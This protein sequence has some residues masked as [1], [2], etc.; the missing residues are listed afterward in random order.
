LILSNDGIA[1]EQSYLSMLYSRLDDLREQTEARLAQV[2]R[3]PGDTPQAHSERDAAAARYGERLA[4]L[5]SAEP[6]LCFGRLDLRDDERRYIGRIGIFDE[7]NGHEPLLVDWRAPA[8][9]PFYAATAASPGPVRRRRHLR[10][11]GRKVVDLQDEVLDLAGAGQSELTGEAALLA[12]LAAGRTG[13]MAD[14]VAT[15]QAEQDRVIR[16]EH[17]GVLVVEGGPGTG[18][19]AVALHRA[20]YLLYTYRKELA[21]RGV[22]I[23][24][25]NQ[26]FL[27]YIDQVLPSLGETGVLLRTVGEL[28]PGVEVTA[29]EPPASAEVKGRP[30]MAEVVAAAVRDRQRLPHEDREIEVSDTHAG[31]GYRRERLTL[32]RD[33]CARARELAR[34]TRRPHNRARAVFVRAVVDA[35]AWQVVE[36]LG[37][38]PYADDPLGGDDAP[39]EGALLLAGGDAA[40]IARELATDAGVRA[41]LDELWPVLTPPRLLADLY[42][43]PDRVTDGLLTASERALL[44]RDPDA[45]W[46]AADVPLLDEAA[47]L[48]GEDDAATRVRAGRAD[49]ERL[50]YAQGVLD[51]AAGSRSTDADDGADPEELSAADLVDAGRLAERHESVDARTTAERAAADRRWTFGHVIVD[52]AQELS[53]MAWRMLMRRCP[54]RWMTLVGDLAQ[55]SDQAGTGS[56]ERA[57][58][59]YVGERWRRERLTVNYRTPAEI[60]TVAADVLAAVDPSLDLPRSVR[61]TGVPP[62]R[63]EV[64]PAGLAGRLPAVIRAELSELGDGRLAV[65][66]PAGLLPLLGEA[67]TAAVPHAAVAPAPE[68]LAHRI[69]VLA[70][71]HAKGLEF[72]GVVVVEPGLILAESTRGGNDLYVALTRATKRLGIVHTGAL[73]AMF[74]PERLGADLASRPDS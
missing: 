45:G 62:W 72:D 70:V 36:R 56:W 16:S 52:E 35:L 44:R 40:V 2:L 60:M 30:V 8:A 43:A 47:E 7:T 14:I 18:K 67:V 69:A 63:L 74:D 22:L 3:E 53:A 28:Y 55:T 9:Q 15:I 51:I 50:A 11:H 4:Q 68:V 57:L 25:P 65:I 71:R 29:T 26:T 21:G 12:A 19:T 27:H 6:A 32:D 48:L 13:R 42:A 5:R 38:D 39:G 46:T 73:P 41:A 17:R 31:F 58:G 54:G 10:T 49:R 1:Y 66:A 37:H 23:V 33:T 59:P 24:G 61:H 34:R 20:A 64:E